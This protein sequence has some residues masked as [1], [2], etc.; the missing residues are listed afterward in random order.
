MCYVLS[1][2]GGGFCG[3]E[4]GMENVRL[5]EGGEEVNHVFVEVTLVAAGFWLRW[6]VAQVLAQVSLGGNS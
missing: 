4:N 6:D 3:D 1:K 5:E 2:G